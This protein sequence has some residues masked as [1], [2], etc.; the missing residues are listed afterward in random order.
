MTILKSE[1]IPNVR[2][3]A[4]AEEVAEKLKAESFSIIVSDYRLGGASGVDMLEEL[5]KNGNKTPVL[6]ISGAPNLSGVV[7]AAV[8]ERV[9]FIAKPF[10]IDE[11]VTAVERLLAP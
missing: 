9:D 1:G 4:S 8:H 7:R 5:R 6:L 3:A 11:L 2:E 10:K